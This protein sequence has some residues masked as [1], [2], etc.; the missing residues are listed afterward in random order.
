MSTTAVSLSV[1]DR[2]LLLNILPTE[3]DITMLRTIRCLREDLSFSDE[4]AK[5]LQMVVGEGQVKWDRTADYQKDIPMGARVRKLIAA[6]L[7]KRSQANKLEERYVGL[8]DR[9]VEE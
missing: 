4:D 9:F 5:A 6:A 1:L 8:Y 2:L 7:I 3:G